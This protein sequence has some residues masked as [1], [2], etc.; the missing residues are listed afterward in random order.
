M[1]TALGFVATLLSMA[2]AFPSLGYRFNFTATRR[3]G[4]MVQLQEIRLYDADGLLDLGDATA[5]NPG[6]NSPNAHRPANI[7]DADVSQ[8]LC[9]YAATGWQEG[10]ADDLIFCLECVN[11]TKGKKWLDFNT[12]DPCVESDCNTEDSPYYAVVDISLSTPI[13]VTA[14]EFITANDNS[15]RD[16]VSWT[17]SALLPGSTTY[18]ELDSRDPSS[19]E[20][21]PSRYTSYGVINVALPPPPSPPPEP[22]A[23]PYPPPSPPEP[24]APP[25]PP[26]TPPPPSTPPPSPPSP[27]YPPFSPPP[28]TLVPASPSPPPPPPPPAVPPFVRS[29]RAPP[30]PPGTGNLAYEVIVS[31]TADGTSAD[32]PEST[33]ADI[34]AALAASLNV[35]AAYVAITV[36]DNADGSGVTLTAVITFADESEASDAKTALEGILADPTAATGLLGVTVTSTPVVSDV[37]T[38]VAPTYEVAVSMD[39]E[40]PAFNLTDAQIA[41]LEQLFADE[42]YAC[43]SVTTDTVDATVTDDA[44]GAGIDIDVVIAFRDLALAEAA[45][46]ELA[47]LF[48]DAANATA[49]LSSLGIVVTGT[50]G[51]D[52]VTEIMSPPPSPPPPTGTSANVEDISSAISSGDDDSSGGGSECG[53]DFCISFLTIGI[54][55][56]LA[57]F[58]IGYYLYTQYCK[59]EQKQVVVDGVSA[60]ALAATTT[61]SAASKDSFDTLDELF[62]KNKAET[63]QKLTPFTNAASER[64]EAAAAAVSSKTSELKADL[65]AGTDKMDAMA[66]PYVADA[67]QVVDPYAHTASDGVE[68][69][70]AAVAARMGYGEEAQEEPVTTVLEVEAVDGPADDPY[71]VVDDPYP[72]EDDVEAAAAESATPPPGAAPAVAG[73]SDEDEDEEALVRRVAWIKFYVTQGDMEKARELGWN[74]DMSFLDGEP[75]T[76][77]AAGEAGEAKTVVA[78]TSMHRI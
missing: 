3:P 13:D 15:K 74:G 40:S 12:Q 56:F 20:A 21:P 75:D 2:R 16:P 63:K 45:Q 53:D 59:P 50:P 18:T 51:V 43:C 62:A 34:E 37:A 24:P 72:D 27:G 31:M 49:F 55:C 39:A 10:Y 38:V 66:Q 29:P 41:L 28:P 73:E 60:T 44:A 14:Y 48:A 68:A 57:S 52:A 46:E 58:V 35:S 17:V 64:I 78:Q 19:V 30:S 47:A 67:K 70:T 8:C 4:A 65:E 36:T 69:A 7:I 42:L 23:P 71:E 6:G 11:K 22:P 33:I 9:L 61:L 32:Y 26:P 1:R 77:P 54:L 76:A 25:M 5:A